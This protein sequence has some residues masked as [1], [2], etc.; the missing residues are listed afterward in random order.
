MFDFC[1]EMSS[2]FLSNCPILHLYLY[3]SIP[4]TYEGSSFSASLL[5]RLTVWFS[6][7][8]MVLRDGFDFHFPCHAL[9]DHL[10]IFFQEMSVQILGSC[11]NWVTFFW[12]NY[13]S[14]L[15]IC[16]KLKKKRDSPKNNDIYLGLAEC[17]MGMCASAMFVSQTGWVKGKFLK[18]KMQK[19]HQ[20]LWSSS[21]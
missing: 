10:Y 8:E 18:I 12:L 6:P 7:C 11:L 1:W 4:G 13:K 9:T 5:T 15:Y 19:I 14:S 17:C 20:I 2:C 21:A 3:N 16:I